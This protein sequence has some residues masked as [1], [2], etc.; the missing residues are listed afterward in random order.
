MGLRTKREGGEMR[1]ITKKRLI[2]INDDLWSLIVRN[3]DN[4][5][6]RMCGTKTKSGEA[7]HIIGRD[8]KALR[9][10]IDNGITLCFYCHRYKIHGGK[11]SE[12][13]KIKFYK[14]V[15]NYDELKTRSRIVKFNL[16]FVIENF[17]RLYDIAMAEN[18]RPDKIVP[19]YIV[20]ELYEEVK[21]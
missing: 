10:D 11:M 15:S 19:R 5:T 12:E 14:S 4:Y 8:N 6:C 9:W 7:H 13:D 16:E 20:K 18:L 1:E 17:N 3:R 21:E 2:Q